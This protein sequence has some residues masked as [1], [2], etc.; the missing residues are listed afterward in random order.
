MSAAPP[1][2]RERILVTASGL[3]YREGLRAV[4]VDRVVAESG[5]AKSTLYKHFPS[6]D[7]LIVACL[8][9]R[10]ASSRSWLE[11]EATR[12]GSTPCARLL[13][14][15][16]VL[17]EWFGWETF[18]GCAFANA[19]LELTDGAHPARA[20]VVAHKDAIRGFMRDLCTEL[21][22][23]DADGL[24]AQLM[25]LYDGA[26]VTAVVRGD[27]SAARD[28]RGAAET[29]LASAAPATKAGEV[30]ERR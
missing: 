11:L 20:V 5:V 17:E 26:I 30:G 19:G 7:A 6:K 1:S 14:I 8:E 27:A 16:A 10:D 2:P 3:F 29:L 18:R 21:D 22:V 9:R 12:R 15:F 23:A 13:G 24:A 4:G 28:A 25:L